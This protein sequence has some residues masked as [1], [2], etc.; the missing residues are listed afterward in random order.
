MNGTLDIYAIVRYHYLIPDA[1][2]TVEV[3]VSEGHVKVYVT[4]PNPNSALYSWMIE[5]EHNPQ[6]NKIETCQSYFFQ[7][8]TATTRR[9]TAFEAT[10][11]SKTSKEDPEALN[12]DQ[13]LYISLVGVEDNNRFILNGMNGN[14]CHECT[15][16]GP[17]TSSPTPH[18]TTAPTCEHIN[19]ILQL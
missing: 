6:R 3:C 12:T 13:T 4:I 15:P 10:S 18:P 9:T 16:D 8:T 5:V 1:G 11:S 19:Y 2:I 17:T 7:K 14:T